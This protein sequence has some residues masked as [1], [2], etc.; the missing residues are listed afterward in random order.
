M[1]S[2][3][4]RLIIQKLTILEPTGCNPTLSRSPKPKILSYEKRRPK[5][6]EMSKLGHGLIYIRR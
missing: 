3:L 5:N 1:K 2:L 4:D 6:I